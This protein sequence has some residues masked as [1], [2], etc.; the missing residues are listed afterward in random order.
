[1]IT[2]ECIDC[3]WDVTDVMGDTV[4]DPTL[5]IECKFI[6]SL[7]T[8]EQQKAVRSLT[9]KAKGD[10]SAKSITCPQCGHESHNINDIAY[11][12]C[13]N[14]HQFHADMKDAAIPN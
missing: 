6:R 8:E 5:C 9:L 1:M 13:V 12:Y 10:Q 7:P 11:E 3:H 14:C 2:Y 4:P